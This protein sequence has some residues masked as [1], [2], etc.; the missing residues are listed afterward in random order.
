M[1]GSRLSISD[2]VDL[3]RCPYCDATW[4]AHVFVEHGL[5]MVL[6]ANCTVCKKSVLHLR[7]GKS[8]DSIFAELRPACWPVN[9]VLQYHSL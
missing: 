2:V 7:R 5:R 9:V 6:R 8:F 4:C 3:A 1:E